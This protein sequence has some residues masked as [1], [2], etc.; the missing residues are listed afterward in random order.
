M[1]SLEENDYD[2]YIYR[3]HVEY[4]H[5]SVGLSGLLRLWLATTLDENAST[6]VPSLI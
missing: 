2:I 1:I 3:L 4:D 6:V 5:A